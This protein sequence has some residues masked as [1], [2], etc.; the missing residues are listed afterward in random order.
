MKTKHSNG[1]PCGA[2]VVMSILDMIEDGRELSVF[3]CDSLRLL[4]F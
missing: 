2:G 1:W 4:S 3:D